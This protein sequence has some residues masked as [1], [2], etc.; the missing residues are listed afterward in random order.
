MDRDLEHLNL[1]S[2]FYY[3]AAGL[4]LLATCFI[5]LYFIVI[6]GVLAF[7]PKGPHGPP[8]QILVPI[9]MVV[10]G[11]VFLLSLTMAFLT[12]L[13]GRFLKQ[14]RHHL[15]CVIMAVIHCL[16]F[17]FGTILGVFTIVVLQRPR[18]QQMFNEMAP[19]A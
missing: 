19:V 5:L 3:I 14:R 6:S 1:L 9:M 13:T 11:F 16:S 15:F 17:P 18:V 7:V 2:I 8:T 12:F 10:G 4:G